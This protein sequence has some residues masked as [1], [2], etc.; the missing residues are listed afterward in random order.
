MISV[1]ER[2]PYKIG[3]QFIRYVRFL[4]PNIDSIFN[5]FLIQIYLIGI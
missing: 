3:Q 1:W 2:G 5:L 4:D